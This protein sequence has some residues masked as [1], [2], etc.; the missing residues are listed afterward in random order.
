VCRGELLQGNGAVPI[1]CAFDAIA[2]Q[3]LGLGAPSLYHY[4]LQVFRMRVKW[5]HIFFCM[6]WLLAACLGQVLMAQ[7]WDW[8][9]ATLGTQASESFGVANDSTG[10]VFVVGG[11]EGNCNFGNGIVLS[12]QGGSRDLFVAKYDPNGS[13]IWA[14]GTGSSNDD[15]ALAIDID[16]AGA[17]YVTGF[18]TDSMRFSGTMGPITVAGDGGREVFV[19]KLNGMTGLV[20]W[21]R[22]SK[23]TNQE[24]GTAITVLGSNVY[25]TGSFEGSCSF[26]N[27]IVN[28]M[29]SS[30]VFVAGLGT[31][32]GMWTLAVAGGSSQ[33]D[34]GNAICNDGT[35]LYLTGSFG[36]A[37]FTFGSTSL[38]SS[39]LTDGFVTK[40]NINGMA[41]WSAYIAGPL[42]NE[43]GNA[44]TTD[45]QFVIVAGNTSGPSNLSFSA[46]IPITATSSA[47]ADNFWCAA[48]R[49]TD[50]E[51]RWAVNEGGAGNDH[52]NGITTCG[53][54]SI[55]IAGSFEQTIVLGTTILSATASNAFLYYLDSP[56]GMAVRALTDIGPGNAS[57]NAI[58][59]DGGCGVSIAGGFDLWLQ[60]DSL[61][62]L[63]AAGSRAAFA[64]H[65]LHV[66][67]YAPPVVSPRT[68][69]ICQGDST[70]LQLTGVFDNVEWSASTDSGATWTVL[71]IVNTAL[72]TVTPS[73]STIYV[74]T[75]TIACDI[76]TDTAWVT[77]FPNP[78]VAILGLPDT[79]C[80]SS[81]AFTFTVSPAIPLGT[82]LF[83]SLGYANFGNGNVQFDPFTAGA[84][85]P[86]P[87]T[88]RYTDALGCSATD[89][90]DIE[91]I[92][93]L[94]INISGL[95]SSYCGGDTLERTVLGNYS[96]L[97]LFSSAGNGFYGLQN[98]QALFRPSAAP[99][100]T[101]LSLTYSFYNGCINTAT[102][103]TIVHG[104]P[105]PQVS[106]LDSSYC[107]GT[108]TDTLTGNYTSGGTFS[109][110]PWINPVSSSQAILSPVFPLPFDTLLVVDYTVV[111]AF[112]CTATWRDS[113]HIVPPP[114]ALA[115]M[116]DS[117]CAGS[118]TQIG[119]A[120]APGT[121]FSWTSNPAF[122][123][124][125]TPEV[126][127]IP[128]TNLLCF[129]AVT[130]PYG[131]IGLD[132][133][134][135]TV[136][137][138]P[139]ADAGDDLSICLGDS[140]VLGGVIPSNAT[141]LWQSTNGFT[142][143]LQHPIATPRMRD[144]FELI[145]SDSLGLCR[146]RD[147]VIV[148]VAL[149]VGL[150]EA[151]PDQYIANTNAT[152][153]ALRPAVGLGTWT[154]SPT[155][156]LL[157]DIHDPSASI[158]GLTMGRWVMYWEVVNA[159]CP[160]AKDSLHIT[161]ETL[162]FPTGFSPNADG[163]ND[164]LVFKGLEHAP[165]NRLQVFNRWGNLVFSQE[166]YDNRW[167][168]SHL[169]QALVDDTY[170]YI[171]EIADRATVS[172][173]LVLKR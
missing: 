82:I 39:G 122:L 68:D 160:S 35:D 146:D 80:K 132:T 15:C 1:T 24:I 101:L 171:L 27:Q 151:G 67:G 72:I 47:L 20:D 128:P 89:S 31:T 30:D 25:V 6:G 98:G 105:Q 7:N 158:Y 97:G 65:Y 18:Y 69:S 56:S 172:N 134:S 16:A 144:Q 125:S 113:T 142:S 107:I 164:V 136:I 66:G 129:L 12:S 52:A 63:S 73:V 168:G 138:Q 135:I 50:G 23:S 2:S 94:N 117:I 116:D 32:T 157:S 112:G 34:V 106:G 61:A 140:V 49:R 41:T 8:S 153:A 156:L 21:V 159:P 170:Y 154:C 90:A 43:T 60:F 28:S 71:T 100:D 161:V 64:A 84:G 19:A 75:S 38:P 5:L 173:F 126:T 131:C 78:Q 48:F 81:P 92:S 29:G 91:V 88:Y 87:I 17:I 143:T 109:A 53:T 76:H 58:G 127:L 133:L 114:Q 4:W 148:D 70:T 3:R 119:V 102:V 55:A 93:E 22:G 108:P 165:Q 59:Y 45:G 54:G 62:Q 110:S 95:D 40:L 51:A 99:H 137:S 14:L 42:T 103:H 33:G 167:D 169:G 77:V 166:A 74:A 96:P 44:L 162:F 139:I 121:S 124:A 85:G 11:F 149:P 147:T 150:V 37:I 36:N 13:I 83:S 86:Y 141:S 145:L 57:A 152:L 46:A 123:L 26:G 111:D 118:S 130:G 115:G 104:G 163:V 155:G 79:I 120:G 10:N 9:S